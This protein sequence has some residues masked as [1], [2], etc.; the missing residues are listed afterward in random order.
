MICIKGILPPFNRRLKIAHS[1]VHRQEFMV[2]SAVTLFCRG[3]G[4]AGRGERLPVPV[5]ELFHGSTSSMGGAV[6]LDGQACRRDWV[7]QQTGKS[8]STLG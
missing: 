3:E 7:S 5:R 2:K 8:E 1:M 4:A 6:H